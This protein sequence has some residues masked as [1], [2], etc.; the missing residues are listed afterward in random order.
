MVQFPVCFNDSLLYLAI[1]LRFIIQNPFQIFFLF[2]FAILMAKTKL[3]KYI[4]S[5]IVILL[6]G[7]TKLLIESALI[8]ALI[9]KILPYFVLG[10]SL[11]A[12]AS[13]A[14]QLKITLAPIMIL[15]SFFIIMETKMPM[16]LIT[17]IIAG[18]LAPLFLLDWTYAV[19][20]LVI[21]FY[22]ILFASKA[23]KFTAI[24]IPIIYIVVILILLTVPTLGYCHTLSEFLKEP[25]VQNFIASPFKWPLI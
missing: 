12:G 18:F 25:A 9:V 5:L 14:T 8:S 6:A 4:L 3:L 17:A 24:T 22:I 23:S 21:Q 20:Y 15:S 19:I 1:I 13:I 7:F 16:Q 2:V 11:F 10:G